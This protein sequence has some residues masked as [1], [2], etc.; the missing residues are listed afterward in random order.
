MAYIDDAETLRERIASLDLEVTTV[1]A[2]EAE[3]FGQLFVNV[4]FTD[5][6]RLY[7]PF[8]HTTPTVGFPPIGTLPQEGESR[9]FPLPIP[10]HVSRTLGEI[11][12]VFVRISGSDGWF[13][14]SVLL[15]ANG[16]ADPL[17]GNRHANQFLDFND[18]VLLLREWSTASFCV[19]P[20]VGPKHPLPSSGYRLLGPVLG[21]VSASTAVVLYRV[22]REGRY[23]FRATD[24][25]S[26]AVVL[27]QVA[28]LE[29]TG[30]FTLTGLEPDRRYAF[31]LR[32]V[33]AGVESPVPGGASQV[34]TYPA[35][36][37]PGT[38][39]V[40]F[41]SCANPDKQAA[42]G[43]WTG[44]RSLA[45][46][47]PDGITPVKLFVHLG[48]TF[49]FYDEMTGEK[50]A[51]RESMH[52]AH[53]SQ[54]RHLEFLDMARAVPCCAVWDDHDFA[55]NNTDGTDL[56][57][58]LKLA[59]KEVW[60][61]YWGN[62]QP[63]RMRDFGLTT[64][65]SH[66]L[67]DL[68]LLDGRFNRDKPTGVCFGQAQINEVL[69]MIRERGAARPRL[70]LLASG[71]NWNHMVTDDKE[72]YGHEDYNLERETFYR[73]LADLMGS[74]I[75]GL[76]LLSGDTHRNEIYSVALG[77][78]R[79][80][81]ELVSSPFTNNTDLEDQSGPIGGERLARFPTGGAAGR[82]GFAT[83]TLDTR[84][85]TE[86][87]WTATVRYYQ[88]AGASEYESRLFVLDNGEFV[89]LA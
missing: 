79:R 2:G 63:T 68:Y 84:S 4:V 1:N 18:D 59:A 54:R 33:R 52:A 10:A 32:F 16:H 70:V 11:A 8:N 5:G 78:E 49:Y 72:N 44:I 64:L 31:D 75:N 82:R 7:E 22:D 26:G 23:R 20:A 3:S 19:A 35:E 58:S 40:A 65:I 29:P 24:T 15:F 87:K 39:C 77:N 80:A 48:D 6:T 73:A 30:R 89:P 45:E 41:G 43:C 42:Q 37:S 86:G 17:I 85:E 74:R 57:P 12:E 66:G 21:Q 69:E 46:H 83:L 34:R 47:P 13:V 28:N 88:E 53:V 9:T 62:D 76:V 56:D 50:V 25:E 36:G 14:G 38:F 81:L 27:D 67:I 51:N 61:Q 71:S 60:L 55:G